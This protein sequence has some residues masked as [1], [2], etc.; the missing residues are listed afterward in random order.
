MTTLYGFRAPPDHKEKRVA[1]LNKIRESLAKFR[2][3]GLEKHL[4]EY[5][6][7]VNMIRILDLLSSRREALSLE[8][9]TAII[10]ETEPTREQLG[11]EPN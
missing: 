4:K 8:A 10:N 2:R 3:T 9:I 1:L 6:H 5:Q 11:E 7:N